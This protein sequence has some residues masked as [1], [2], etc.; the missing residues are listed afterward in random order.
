MSFVDFIVNY[1][2][3]ILVVILFIVVCVILV[4]KGYAKY[5]KQICFSLVCDAESA[6]GSGTGALKYAAVTT[7]LYDKLPAVCKLLFTEKQI[8]AFIEDAVAKMKEW[9][10][11]NDKANALITAPLI[12]T[13]KSE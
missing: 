12:E 1:W 4:K 9:L 5:V 3:S 10:K 2:S 8:D 6:F 7:W 13:E 11:T